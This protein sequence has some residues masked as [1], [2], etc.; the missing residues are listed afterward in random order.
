MPNIE[1]RFEEI[2]KEMRADEKGVVTFTLRGSSRILGLAENT[3]ISAFSPDR[4][5][6]SAIAKKL[7]EHGIDVIAL[8][9]VGV[10]DTVLA[11]IAEFYAHEA[12]KYCTPEAK[13][14]CTICLSI[15][16]R[17]WGQRLLGWKPPQEYSSDF[18]TQVLTTLAEMNAKIDNQQ[19]E[20]LILRP[21]VE[22]YEKLEPALD[23]L[24]GLKPLLEAVT[25]ELK[26][27]PN[28]EYKI[29]RKWL[30]ILNLPPLGRGANISM[31]KLLSPFFKICSKNESIIN[32]LRG[33]KKYPEAFLPVI[34]YCYTYT[35]FNR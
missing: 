16:L 11:L 27:N 8:A 5:N 29:L 4:R 30:H 13:D 7:T 19:S 22:K 33:V 34:K 14:T 25:E 21:V 32:K 31:G 24:E 10:K 9:N 2:K 1:K 15:G 17:T 35:L 12:G 6:S 28:Q 23:F 18:Q 26:E 3:L 20:L